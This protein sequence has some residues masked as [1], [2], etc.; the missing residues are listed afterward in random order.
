MRIPSL[1]E[2]KRVKDYIELLV[3]GDGKNQHE[4]WS[5]AEESSAIRWYKFS[6]RMC[7]LSL[8]E[9]LPA[10]R[11][12]PSK[13]YALEVDGEEKPRPWQCA[14]MDCSL[15]HLRRL[16]QK[17]LGKLTALR[18]LNLSC[19]QLRDI[20]GLQSLPNLRVLDLS[21]NQIESMKRG[22][23]GLKKL[24]ELNLSLNKIKVIEGMDDLETLHTLRINCNNANLLG[25]IEGLSGL[26][27]FEARRNALTEVNLLGLLVGLEV[28]DICH[29]NIEN[30]NG[31]V[32][33]IMCMKGLKEVN[34]YGNPCELDKAFKTRLVQH[35]G[36]ENID[37]IP[38]SDAFRNQLINLKKKNDLNAVVEATTAEYEA[39]IEVERM[40][41]EEALGTLRT[42]ENKIEHDFH[43][44]KQRIEQ[45]MDECMGYVQEVA[46]SSAAMKV[47]WIATEEGIKQW[48]RKI[49]KEEEARRSDMR[50]G[51]DWMEGS[52]VRKKG[53]IET[54]VQ[55]RP[56]VYDQKLEQHMQGV[57]KL[58]DLTFKKPKVWEPVR[59]KDQMLSGKRKGFG[60]GEKPKF[61]QSTL[62][63][64]VDPD[65]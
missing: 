37:G 3:I 5:M 43:E 6:L 46:K 11:Q 60:G 35:R 13:A 32:K 28:L 38:I 53:E 41:K 25:S 21:S 65:L 20:H 40:K 12:P 8:I 19:N 54:I 63:E 18:Y 34:A 49:E 29:N 17:E 22:L 1:L 57:E 48:K 23:Q 10:P 45:E 58:G 42:R 47:S 24:K 59:G 7:R 4:F 39:R 55:M 2:G 9:G 16:D 30:I 51:M 33:T 61:T 64:W 50:K 44:Y 36:I 52:R 14:A 26:R 31:F 15:N 27:I 56:T 62:G